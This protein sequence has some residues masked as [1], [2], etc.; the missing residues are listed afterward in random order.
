ML[1]YPEVFPEAAEVTQYEIKYR[2]DVHLRLMREDAAKV[3]VLSPRPLKGL[4]KHL[5]M[6]GMVSTRSTPQVHTKYWLYRVPQGRLQ[7]A[8][9]LGGELIKDGGLY[10]TI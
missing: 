6:Q 8:L 1:L 5:S 10:G 3:R 2:P 9:H 7:E 4:S